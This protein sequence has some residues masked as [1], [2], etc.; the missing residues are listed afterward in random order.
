MI[1]YIYIK[2]HKKIYN[3]ILY[4]CTYVYL[5]MYVY[6]LY[7]RFFIYIIRIIYHVL[8]MLVALFLHHYF[9]KF[10][11]L[12]YGGS[13]IG[14]KRFESGDETTCAERLHLTHFPSCINHP[15]TSY[16]SLLSSKTFREMHRIAGIGSYLGVLEIAVY[17]NMHTA[18]REL[19]V[20]LWESVLKVENL[21]E[22]LKQ[23]L[24]NFSIKAIVHILQ[25]MRYR[26]LILS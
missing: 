7:T 23:F 25:S 14:N 21:L 13:V 18:F 9:G 1:F 6:I 17:A 24:G 12:M 20:P 22:V 4:V 11:P 2:C 5:H 8:K 3:Y 16:F 19:K 26:L 10:L 15:L